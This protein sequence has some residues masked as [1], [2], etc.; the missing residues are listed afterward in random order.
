MSTDTNPPATGTTEDGRLYDT[1]GNR[2]YDMD[3]P[4]DAAAFFDTSD[5]EVRYEPRH[6]ELL[7]GE[8]CRLL[9]DTETYADDD[10]WTSPRVARTDGEAA[11]RVRLAGVHAAIATASATDAQA[12]TLALLSVDVADGFTRLAD[13]ADRQCA[14]L[15]E[16][17]RHTEETRQA[18]ADRAA[19][20]IDAEYAASTSRAGFYALAALAVTVWAAL[21]GP[22]P[23]WSWLPQD[24]LPGSFTVVAGLTAVALAAIGALITATRYA[25]ARPRWSAR[26]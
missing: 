9:D 1:H 15:A 11:A 25:E 21:G 10:G 16:L 8:A 18:A 22:R 17:A 20:L 7:I 4:A 24:A 26:R 6:E 12:S 13:V 14:V 3:N 2:I 5:T 23:G 19:A